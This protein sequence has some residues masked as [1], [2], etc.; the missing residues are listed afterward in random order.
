MIPGKEIHR[1]YDHF[2]AV[3]V[4]DDGQKRYLSFGSV[5][6]QSCVLKSEPMVPQ[7]E[8]TRIMLL[9]LL[10]SKPKRVLSLG[11]GAGALNTCLHHALS[12][13]K[14]EVVEIRP[15]VVEAAYRYFQLPRGKRLVVHTQDAVAFVAADLSQRYDVI[16]SDIYEESGVNE[17]QLSHA[18]IEGCLDK[19][20]PQGWLV[21][22]CWREHQ[23]EALLS[24][25][26]NRCP[27]VRSCITQSGNWVVFA[28]LSKTI[29]T[30]KGL[31]VAAKALT[32][33]L[34]FSLQGYLRKLQ[35]HSR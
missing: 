25:L 9:V 10:W 19:L 15:A 6:E 12:A 4:H 2:G 26:Q 33:Q 17:D 35:F 5:D 24:Y 28:G 31:Q 20:K 21:L 32:P 29:E 7:H 18:Y 14:Q 30:Q 11:L 23:S 27:D 16:F 34:G 8:Y 13:A 3:R 22:N 1:S